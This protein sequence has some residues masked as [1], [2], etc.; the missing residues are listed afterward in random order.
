MKLAVEY[1]DAQSFVI[2]VL[3]DRLDQFDTTPDVG[4]SLPPTWKVGSTPFLK[5]DLDGSALVQPVFELSTVRVTAWVAPTSSGVAASP[6]MAKQLAQRARG[7]LLA[8][9]PIT[10]GAGL[11]PAFD[12][13]HKA[14]LMSFT[15]E[16]RLR[17][18]PIAG[19]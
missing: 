14:E 11:F 9:G 19:S 8:E 16:V 15:V 10:P 7:L 5:V 12:P 1:G 6:T 17:S 2:D 4:R 13:D 3:L 18:V